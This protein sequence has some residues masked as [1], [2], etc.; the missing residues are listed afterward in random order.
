MYDC[1]VSPII[2]P[3]SGESA[4]EIGLHCEYAFNR[5]ATIKHQLAE[6]ARAGKKDSVEWDLLTAER[7]NAASFLIDQFLEIF[8]KYPEWHK[9]HPEEHRQ[10]SSALK[11][12]CHA[13][14]TEDYYFDDEDKELFEYFGIL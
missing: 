5:L 14:V 7:R 3:E 4:E 10:L 11:S 9:T 2:I 13:E 1:T 6:L 8:D 12:L